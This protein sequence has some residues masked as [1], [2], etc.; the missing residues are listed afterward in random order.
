MDRAK[1]GRPTIGEKKREANKKEDRTLQFPFF[2]DEL[3]LT[4]G[5]I[6]RIYSNRKKKNMETERKVVE[7][8]KMFLFLIVV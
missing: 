4:E 2:A 7:K 6:G 5:Q 8:N 1:M 3:F